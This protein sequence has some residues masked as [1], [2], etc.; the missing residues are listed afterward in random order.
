MFFLRAPE[1][2]V[3]KRERKREKERETFPEL[4]R[5]GAAL[6]RPK[7]KYRHTTA[8][9][10]YHHITSHHITSH[11]IIPSNQ[12]HIT[13]SVTQLHEARGRLH[14]RV[15]GPCEQLGTCPVLHDD[16]DDEKDEEKEGGGG[17][18]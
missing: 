12:N 8:P 13:Q 1:G 7:R 3:L 4:Q 2:I 16:D 11:P 9:D 6:S 17:G 18:G 15:V 5:G 14:P 10:A